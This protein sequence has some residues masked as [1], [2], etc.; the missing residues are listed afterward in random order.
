MEAIE[1]PIF[2]PFPFREQYMSGD[3]GKIFLNRTNDLSAFLSKRR[4]S[5]GGII[6][7]PI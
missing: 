2:P 7:S 1:K 5:I 6:S 3:M 4:F